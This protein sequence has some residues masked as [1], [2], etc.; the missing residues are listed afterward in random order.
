M[1]CF[2]PQSF[3]MPAVGQ[4]GPEPE[5]N[6]GKH[7]PAERHRGL[8]VGPL[9]SFP[10]LVAGI[11]VLILPLLQMGWEYLSCASFCQ[12]IHATKDV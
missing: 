10:K 5:R 3:L 8:L 1:R 7:L 9:P 12:P 6:L 4:V 2:G 11:L